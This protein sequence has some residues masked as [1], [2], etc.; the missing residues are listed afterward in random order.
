M[1]E[2]VYTVD[3]EPEFGN[4]MKGLDLAERVDRAFKRRMYVVK[5]EFPELLVFSKIDF[6]Y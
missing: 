3:A 4:W 1:I 6:C 2:V 5:I